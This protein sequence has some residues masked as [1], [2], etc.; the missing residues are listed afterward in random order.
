MTAND[1]EDLLPEPALE[2]DHPGPADLES[3]LFKHTLNEVQFHPPVTMDESVSLQDA[4]ETMRSQHQACILVTRQGRLSGIFTHTDVVMKAF[5]G[6]LD[7]AH[8]P[9]SQCMTTDPET[10]PPDAS[11]AFA[12]NKMAIDGFHRLPLMDPD[13]KPVG[14]VSMRDLIAFLAS[15]FPQDIFNLPPDPAKWF[16][17]RD[18]A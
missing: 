17:G 2:E 7:L 12:L 18:G 11:V 4:I 16:R 5:D 6:P 13:G 10:L 14:V 1:K 15:L 9:L 8:T 3:F